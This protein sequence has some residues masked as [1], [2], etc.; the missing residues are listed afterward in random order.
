MENM[1]VVPITVRH[2]A[3]CCAFADSELHALREIMVHRI[4]KAGQIII[5]DEEELSPHSVVVS[6]VVKLIKSLPDGRQQI[7]G[8]L[9]ASDFLGRVFSATSHNFAEAVT[10]VELC[11]FPHNHFER[12]V[13]THPAFERELLKRTLS[14]LDDARD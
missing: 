4:Y 3:I 7:L 8:L 11:C 14:D 12:I 13:K 1:Q 5:L 10:D 6:G 2:H 9:F